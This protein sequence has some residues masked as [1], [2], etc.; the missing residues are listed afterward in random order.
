[1]SAPAATGSD[2]EAPVEVRRLLAYAA[3]AFTALLVIY[4]L[5]VQTGWGQRL[6]QAA[7]AGGTQAPLRAQQAAG[8]LLGTVSVAGLVIGI[9][10][11]GCVAAARR[12]PGLILVPA[13]VIGVTMISAEI[14]KHMLLDRPELLATPFF[15]ENTY[16]SGHTATAI[17]TGLAALLVAPPRLRAPVAVLAFL[18]SA[19]FGVF[20]VTAGWHL[21]S[22]A[23]GSYALALTVACLVMAVVYKISPATLRRER[24]QREPVPG[25]LVAGR[26]ELAG[27]GA[28]I[29]FFFGVI[30]FASLRYG[31]D[32]DWTRIDAAY[33][34]AMATTVFAAAL[35]VS[36]LLRAISRPAPDR[37]AALR[38]DSVSS[39]PG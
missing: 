18:G 2:T 26:L 37:G 1:L 11:L 30:V 17:S 7:F 3:L 10:V 21:P 9:L 6:D 36:S 14:L 31:P 24:A 23:L 22:D 29:V 20:V 28:A 19:G 39:P 34:G 27:L 32:I 4:A 5:A 38:R 16:P 15:T 8:R 33:L 35:T 13:A 12:R 25:A